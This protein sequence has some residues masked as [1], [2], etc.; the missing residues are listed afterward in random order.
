MKRRF[1][2]SLQFF[3]DDP[4]PAQDP[5]PA[6]GGQTLSD[7]VAAYEA[8]LKAVQDERDL[9]RAE[10]QEHKKAISL[11]LNGRTSA[12]PEAPD[13]AAFAKSCKF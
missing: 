3:A 11:I 12:P 4:A 2:I 7:V 9:A 5:A 10:V 1:H 8:K 13:A 6:D